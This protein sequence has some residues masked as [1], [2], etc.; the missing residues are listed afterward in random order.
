MFDFST[1]PVTGGGFITFPEWA[2]SDL[3]KNVG[4]GV[5][6]LAG[7]NQNSNI[8]GLQGGVVDIQPSQ[9]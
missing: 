8:I 4:V 1:S 2:Y 9:S 5:I 3:A 7:T 6:P